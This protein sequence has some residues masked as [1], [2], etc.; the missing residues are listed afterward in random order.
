MQGWTLLTNNVAYIFKLLTLIRQDL[1]LN[2]FLTKIDLIT[3][4]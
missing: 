1:I 3:K 4:V 2:L